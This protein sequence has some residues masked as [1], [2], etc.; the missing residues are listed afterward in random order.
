MIACNTSD[1]NELKVLDTGLF[2]IQ[3]PSNWKYKE[4]QG[5]DSQVG[6]IKGGRIKLDFDW[7]EMGYANNLIQTKN[8]FLLS[9]KNSMVPGPI[10]YGEEGVTYVLNENIENKR[11]ELIKKYGS[12]DSTKI[13][14]EELQIPINEVLLEKDDYYLVS[15]YRDTTTRMKIEIPEEIMNHEI[16]YDTIGQYV[17]KTIKSKSAEIGTTGIYIEDLESDFNFNLVGYD[18]SKQN[19]DIVLEVFKTIKLKR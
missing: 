5:I 2:E 4:K 14:V 3:V 15:K 1:S 7:S 13:R 19:Q 11:N 16:A 10:P 17:I 6:I 12:S 8:E 9:K 18:L